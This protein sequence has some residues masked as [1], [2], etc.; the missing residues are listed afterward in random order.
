MGGI[1]MFTVKLGGN[2]KRC[3]TGGITFEIRRSRAQLADGYAY[4][5]IPSCVATWHKAPNDDW[6]VEPVDPMEGDYMGIRV[7]DGA[8]HRVVKVGRHFYAQLVAFVRIVEAA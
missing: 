7:I 4:R 5:L 6:H 1:A 3:H 2:G 8:N